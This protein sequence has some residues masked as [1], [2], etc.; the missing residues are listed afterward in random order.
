LQ[1]SGARAAAC[2]EAGD[3]QWCGGDVGWA[4]GVELQATLSPLMIVR[5]TIVRSQSDVKE[6]ARREGADPECGSE[7]LAATSAP[8]R[9]SQRDL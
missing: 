5:P 2:G 3:G 1:V 4:E 6:L 9:R 7:A 8:S